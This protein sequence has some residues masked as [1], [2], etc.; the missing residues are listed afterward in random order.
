MPEVAEHR[1]DA[2]DG[3]ADRVGGEITRA[4]QDGK[5]KTGRVAERMHLTTR[6]LQRRLR[7]SGTSFRAIVELS[8]T[9]RGLG[10]AGQLV[11]GS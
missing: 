9:M 7:E 2:T 4:M 11:G 8:G 1:Q 3:D 10:D 5:P 6:R